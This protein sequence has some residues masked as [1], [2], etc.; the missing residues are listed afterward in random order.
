MYFNKK[1]LDDSQAI[2][3]SIDKFIEGASFTNRCLLCKGFKYVS[4]ILQSFRGKSENK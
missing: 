3:I 4:T 1:Q 2:L